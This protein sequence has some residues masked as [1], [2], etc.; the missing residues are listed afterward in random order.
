M[1]KLNSFILMSIFLLSAAF[2]FWLSLLLQDDVKNGGSITDSAFMIS[3]ESG[4]YS[5]SLRIRITPVR[6]AVIYYTTDG[7]EPSS[8]SSSSALYE[9][10]VSLKAGFQERSHSLRFRLYFDDGTSSK[11]YSY[12]YI[13][14]YFV[15]SRYDTYVVNILGDPDGLYSEE[16]GIFTNYTL[17]GEASERP[18][19]FQIF[20][21]TGKLLASQNCGLRIFGNFSRGKAQKSFQLFARKD[22]DVYGKFHLSLFPSARR[23]ADG[24]I[25]DRSNRLV[26]R[27]SGNDF[28][29]AFLRDALFQQLADDYGFPLATPYVPATVYINGEYAGFYWIKEPFSGGQMEELYGTADGHFE[30]VTLQEFYATAGEDGEEKSPVTE[31]YQSLYDTYAEAD[32]TDEAVYR[33]LCSRIDLDNYLSYYA[34]EI[35]IGNKDWPYNNVRAWRY[36]ADDGVYTEGTVFD[37][38]YRYLFFDTDYGFGL[39]DDVP[40]YACE[41]DNIAVLLNNYQSPLFCSLMAREDCR[42]KFTTFV[43]DLMNGSFSSESVAETVQE[44]TLLRDPE[45]SFYV[46]NHLPGIADMDTVNAETASILAFAN[47]RPG[48]MHTFLQ[49]DYALFYP[50]FLHLEIPAG[51]GVSVNS[52]T[53]TGNGFS[54]IYYADNA[55]TLKASS[56][57]G[58]CFSY[59]LINGMPYTEKELTL[60]SDAL[61]ELLGIPAQDMQDFIP[62]EN[63]GTPGYAESENNPRLEISLVVADRTDAVPV[64]SRI[65]ARGTDDLVEIANPSEHDVSLKGLYLSDTAENL[66]KTKLPGK[67]LA[68]GETIVFYGKKNRRIQNNSA[69]PLG[70]NLRKEEI[71]YLSDESGTVLEEIPIPDMG[72]EDSDYVR[73]AFTGKFY[74]MFVK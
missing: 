2:L 69:A 52:I 28:G 15:R 12:S 54:G 27:N 32:L 46:E 36:L 34:M 66:K 8:T 63:F 71:L 38:R 6:D 16:N 26:F 68:P 73:N 72:R 35:Y 30:R 29:K 57:E 60:S 19:H 22:Y 55:L 7:S 59:W 62:P 10:P 56:D 11:V 51:A 9:R 5:H 23:E 58:H 61:K 33:E 40:G 3:H 1:K 74:E 67:V 43:C 45:L 70:F 31:D 4:F 14:G 53:D 47:A 39:T 48:Y 42:E 13:L 18:V 25:S 17:T 37:G 24:T 65:R 21:K 49:R 64:I 44:L 20:D 50:Y 41:E